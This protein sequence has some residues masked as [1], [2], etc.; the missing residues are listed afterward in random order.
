MKI[1]EKPPKLDPIFTSENV[2]TIYSLIGDEE[3]KRLIRKAN[4]SYMCWD[5]FKHQEI[6]KKIAPEIAWL[7]LKIA[8]QSQARPLPAKDKDNRV[9]N[10]W[11][12]DQA[13]EDL[14][15]I[16]NFAGGL[17]SL[18]QPSINRSTQTHYLVHSLMEEAISSSILEGAATTEKKAK[19]MLV[20]GRKPVSH[21]DKM[22]YNNYV[23]IKQLDSFK[24]EPLSVDLLNRIHQTITEGTLNNPGTSGRFRTTDDESIVIKDDQGNLLFEPPPAEEVVDRINELIL[25]TNMENKQGE[26]IHPVVKAIIL[27][28]WLAYVHPFVDG[29]GRTARALFYWYML[30]KNYWIMEYLSISQIIL[31]SPTQYA[32]A[33]LYSEMDDQDLTYF[34]SY[35]LQVIRAGIEHLKKFLSERQERIKKYSEVFQKD[36]GFNLRQKVLLQHAL[37]HHGHLYSIQNHK[38]L[39]QITYQTARTDLLGLAQKGFLN[40]IKDGKKF[41]FTLDKKLEER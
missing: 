1:P 20:S 3:I 37:Q 26:F 41:Y 19:E 10:F 6:P 2:N 22:I 32:R 9:F 27:H 29:N 15:T 31:K 4:K 25:F 18:D 13:L 28:F 7:S 30:K 14:H 21:A 38:N 12:P 24:D 40:K 39:H 8:R 34:I 11:L 23:T 17:I 5:K 36:Q 16:D 33:Y 35:N